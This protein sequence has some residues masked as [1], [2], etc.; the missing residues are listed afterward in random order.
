MSSTLAWPEP[1]TDADI[2][3]WSNFIAKYAEDPLGFVLAAYPWGESGTTLAN[4]TGPDTWQVVIL[5][6]IGKQLRAGVQ[7]VKIA[8]ASGHGSGKS[9]LMSW[10]THWFQT[11]YPNNKARV[12]A[13]TMPQLMSTTWREVAK[14]WELAIN[15]WQFKWTATKYICTYA[16]NTWYSE[17]IA[18]SEH[19]SQAFAGAHEE[20]VMIQFDEASA[21]ADSIW[22]VIDAGAFTT[23]GI[24]LCFGNPSEADGRFAECFGKSKHRWT[25]LHVDA[26]DAKKANKEK[27][28]EMIADWGIDSDYVRVRI[29][30]LFPLHGSIGFITSAQVTMCHARHKLIRPG[31]IPGS[32]PLLM[33]V[34]VARQGSDQSV[35]RLRKGRYV[36]PQ[37]YRYR[38]PDLMK[39]ASL[40]AQHI[41]EH[42]PDVVYVD[43]SGGYGAGVVDRLRQLGFS[44]V[45]IE[46]GSSA[47]ED[48]KFLNKR[49]EIWSR[50]RDWM[51]T[52]GCLPEDDQLRTALE[53]PAYGYD[54][55]TERLK[56]ESKKD[57]K[58]RGGASPDD[59]DALA[60]TFS[61]LVPVKMLDAE[62]S[63]EP[64]VV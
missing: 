44:I 56:L 36:L 34:D 5:D 31:D 28:Q 54:S 60:M 14:W 62:M 53:C 38:I 21:I 24:W 7:T 9:T 52:E 32:V 1:K 49:A 10:L 46:F 17:A 50:M 27:Q 45:G 29:L 55:R 3:A 11:C 58:A 42:E 6:E 41:R 64:D 33:G 59:A 13:G 23:R 35:I 51:R 8:V 39:L 43:A 19:N 4:E 18:W 22:D 20:M 57:I 37:V 40:V 12:T 15:K 48:K 2:V 30:G 16:P 25:T 26:R 47:D 61:M 63:W